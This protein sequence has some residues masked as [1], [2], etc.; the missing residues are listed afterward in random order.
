MIFLQNRMK[1]FTSLIKT[2]NPA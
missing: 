1:E 2:K